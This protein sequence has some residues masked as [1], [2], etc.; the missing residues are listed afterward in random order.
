MPTQP[1]IELV[2][3]VVPSQVYGASSELLQAQAMTLTAPPSHG[4]AHPL[5]LE[6]GA[7]VHQQ[8]KCHEVSQKLEEDCALAAQI[9][10]TVE[11]VVWAKVFNQLSVS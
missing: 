11:V 4:Y 3:T 2:A 5:K 1:E 9:Y 6:Y 10:N 8:Q 7:F